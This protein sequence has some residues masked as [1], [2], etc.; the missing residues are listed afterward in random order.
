MKLSLNFTLAEFTISE[1]AARK[2]IDNTP[3]PGVMAA[4]ERTAKGLEAVRLS[5]RNAPIVVTS[6]YR[7][8]A[9]NAAVGGQPNSQHMAGEA[10]DFI[11]PRFGTP[12][13]VAAALIKRGF[14]F[15]QLILEFGRWVHIS[16]AAKP[17]G[18]ALLIDSSGTRPLVA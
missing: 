9:L 1:T 5:L 3:P 14:V 10:V 18:T 2:G 7:S 8:P 6:G 12:A 17:R 15:D 16:F 13:Q 4:L 11:C